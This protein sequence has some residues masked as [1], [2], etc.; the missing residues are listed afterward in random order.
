MTGSKILAANSGPAPNDKP[1]QRVGSRTLQ[2]AGPVGMPP[3]VQ[4]RTTQTQSNAERFPFPMGP[5]GGDTPRPS[6]TVN[7]RPLPPPRGSLASLNNEEFAQR[8][9]QAGEYGA[10]AGRLARD[11]DA[12]NE[13]R[14]VVDRRPA[15]PGD[16]SNFP[17]PMERGGGTGGESP[18][19]LA[20]RVTNTPRAYLRAVAAQE[21]GDDNNARNPRSSATGLFQF[22]EG[23]WLQMMRDNGEQFGLPAEL[24]NAIRTR[25]NGS[26]YVA[27]EATRNRIMALRTDPEWSALMGGALFHRE[28]ATIQRAV[29]RPITV[30]DVYLG[31]FLGGDAAGFWLRQ[32]QEGRGNQ[33]A[34]QAI[35][36]F[37]ARDPG[38]AQRVIEQNPRQF[39]QGVTVA[40]L[41]RMQ[42]GDLIAHGERRGVPAAELRA[43]VQTISSGP[44]PSGGTKQLMTPREITQQANQ[45][46]WTVRQGEEPSVG[47]TRTDPVTGETVLPLPEQQRIQDKEERDRDEEA[48]RRNRRS[49]TLRRNGIRVTQP[50]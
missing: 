21:G 32:I 17:F 8:R 47:A 33:S 18:I 34:R 7:G 3:P 13:T 1:L 30:A 25:S 50:F 23:T 26:A 36:R 5:G 31:H 22:T 46:D 40:G 45:R 37:Y 44:K 4:S 10:E 15:Q 29:G 14:P 43:I 12:R 2:G 41:Y 20:A 49:V 27:D 16:A 24:R 48:V 11:V 42:T 19:D 38:A 6:T 39:A 28:A 9:A 35:Q